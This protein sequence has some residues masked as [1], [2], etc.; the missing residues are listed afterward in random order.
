MGCVRT[1]AL[2]VSLLSAQ[3]ACL[4]SALN[5]VHLVPDAGGDGTAFLLAS[6]GRVRTDRGPIPLGPQALVRDGRE[7]RSLNTENGVHA[8]H[9]VHKLP[10]FHCRGGAAGEGVSARIVQRL[11]FPTVTS[12]LPQPD[13]E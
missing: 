1:P 9:G 5:Q 13:T 10:P 7:L 3:T 12:A 8:V 6:H 2:G 4:L 11:E